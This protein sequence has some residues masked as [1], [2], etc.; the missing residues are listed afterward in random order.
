[1]NLTSTFW[2]LASGL[3]AGFI[4]SI[5]GGGGLITVPALAITLGA[6]VE[7]VGTNKIAGTLGALTA[8]LVYRRAGHFVL[9]PALVFASW[10]ALGSLT[11][12][13]VAAWIPASWFPGMLLVTC[14]VVLIVALRKD[15]WVRGAHVH[16]TGDD[17]NT[18]SFFERSFVASG[19]ACGFYDGAWG[20]GG[21]TFMFL[22]LFF[23]CRLTLLQALAASKLVNFASAATALVSFGIQ[24]HVRWGTGS[25][26]AAG[27][28]VGAAAGS[29]FASR[30]ATRIV[31][32]VLVVVVVLLILKVLQRYG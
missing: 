5:A 27:V 6:G 1:M 14:P 7:A 32:P 2:I 3:V 11:G 19:L 9:R 13:L 31:R 29:R 30:S 23:F 18:I 4:D 21:G 8:F 24:G 12:S 10:V 22:A 28:I 26:I 17:L 15:L 16:R 25:L 20:P